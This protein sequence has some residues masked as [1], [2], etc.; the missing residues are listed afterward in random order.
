MVITGHFIDA[1]WKLHKRILSFVKVSAPKCG[2]DV[3]GAIF[4]C[5]NAWGIEDKVFSVS[6]VMLLITTLA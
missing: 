1:R 6:I 3:V 2:I 4:K 5:L